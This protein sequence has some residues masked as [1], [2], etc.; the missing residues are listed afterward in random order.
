LQKHIALRLAPAEARQLGS[1]LHEPRS[2]A[3]CLTPTCQ[4]VG[5]WESDCPGDMRLVIRASGSLAQS[6]NEFG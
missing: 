1:D 4:N 2:A 3:G 5:E 6:G